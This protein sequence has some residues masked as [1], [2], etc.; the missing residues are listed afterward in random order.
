MAAKGAA[1]FLAPFPI[2]FI[3]RRGCSL[4]VGIFHALNRVNKFFA[5][6]GEHLLFVYIQRQVKAVS[7][8]PGKD[9]PALDRC[10]LTVEAALEG[11]VIVRNLLLNVLL[12]L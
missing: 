8:W 2:A 9:C 12:L 11:L 7:F 1:T 5:L 3:D 4:P 6:L 10:E